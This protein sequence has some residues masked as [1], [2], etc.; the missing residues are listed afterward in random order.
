MRNLCVMV[1]DGM[2]EICVKLGGFYSAM[3]YI[4]RGVEKR[5]G[6]TTEF[7]R[8]LHS[9]FHP[10]IMVFQSINYQLLPTFNIVNKN[11]NEVILNFNNYWRMSA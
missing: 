8:F 6:F 2:G 10:G 1:V 5:Y 7:S 4:I 11:N 3:I 9:F